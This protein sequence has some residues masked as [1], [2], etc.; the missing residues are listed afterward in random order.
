MKKVLVFGASGSIGKAFLTHCKTLGYQVTGITR[1]TCDLTAEASIQ[2]T[3]ETLKS[4]GPFDII[5]VAT[6]ILHR[7]NIQPEKSL[8]Q[9]NANQLKSVVELNTVGPILVL[10]HCLPL[11][12]KK[13]PAFF[14][15]LSARVGSIS[16]NR[17]GGWY[18]YRASKAALNMLLKTASIELARTYPA[19]TIA[20]LH[21]GTVDSRLS[22]PFQSHIPAG[23]LFTPAFSAEK[24]LTVIEGLTPQDSGNCFAWDG[25]QIPF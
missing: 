9:L 7:G 5:L 18:S 3:V 1:D 25:Q 21:P 11:L 2:T 19:L 15:A 20:G 4:Q 10:K 8:K 23:K 16:D 14:G 12:S 17:L 22:Q 24:L 13:Q 6:G